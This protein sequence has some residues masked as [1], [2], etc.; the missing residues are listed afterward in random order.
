MYISPYVKKD[1]LSIRKYRW[2]GT[3]FYTIAKYGCMEGFQPD[4]VVF[5]GGV[6]DTLD[7]RYTQSRRQREEALQMSRSMGLLRLASQSDTIQSTSL[8]TAKPRAGL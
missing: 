6:N 7:K 3:Q 4:L 5:Y 8:V 1:I 2:S